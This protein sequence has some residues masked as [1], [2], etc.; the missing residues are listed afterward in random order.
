MLSWGRRPSIL[1]RL[2]KALSREELTARYQPIVSLEDGRWI[3]AEAVIAWRDADSREVRPATLRA[4]AEHSG[5]SAPFSRW[6]LGRIAEEL[7]DLLAEERGLRIAMDLPPV[8]L[9]DRAVAEEFERVFEGRES[10]L[11]QL[12]VEVEEPGLVDHAVLLTGMGALQGI[13]VRVGIDAMGSGS[14]G[15]DQLHAIGP[16]YL[17][18]V[19]NLVQAIG[20]GAP[21]EGVAEKVA[22]LGRLLDVEVVALG[23]E[24]PSQVEYLAERGVAAGLGWLYGKPLPAD[25]FLTS[26]YDTAGAGKASAAG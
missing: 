12:A 17:N 5:L 22:T 21:S 25:E 23:V 4:L 16:D 20:S 14:L 26:F 8:A 7:A 18:I 2:R 9:A 10:A 24:H 11:R 1:A 13:G 3:G 15:P 19:G 6:L